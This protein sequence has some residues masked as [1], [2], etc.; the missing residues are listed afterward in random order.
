MERY[1]NDI[2]DI[3]QSSNVDVAKN[4]FTNITLNYE[5]INIQTFDNFLYR[6]R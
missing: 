5:E 1:L 6:N 4:N 3:S 2:N